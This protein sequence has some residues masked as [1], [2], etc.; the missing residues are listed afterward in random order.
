MTTMPTTTPPE[1]THRPSASGAAHGRHHLQKG[2][3][4]GPSFD[5]PARYG[6][7][8]DGGTGLVSPAFVNHDGSVTREVVQLTSGVMPT[9]GQMA[10]FERAY[11]L[12]D[13]AVSY[14][15]V[16]SNPDHTDV[17][18]DGRFPAWFFDSPGAPTERMAIVVH[19]QNGLRNDGLR[20]AD[21][22][23]QS[24]ANLPLLDITY[25]NDA[26]APA[27]PSGRLQYGATE[28]QDLDAAVTWARDRGARDIVLIGQSMGGAVVAGFLESSDQADVVSQVVLDAPMLSLSEVIDNGARSAMPVT[29][30]AVP[31]PII[32]TAKQFASLRY[33]VDWSAV[34]YLDD[35]SWVRVPTLVVHGTGDPRVPVTVSQEL[36]AA[37]PDLVTLETF[38]GALHVESWNFDRARYGDLVRS[39][40]DTTS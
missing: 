17:V 36:K 18:V 5:A 30:G 39:F 20:V 33:G 35:T 24:G 15:P 16:E 38:P 34:D 37:Q 26:G 11:W 12:G 29:G 14:D 31:A 23:A 21:V 7:A 28:W 9:A 25:R 10:A 2:P 19:G 27:D 13:P 40:L 22:L 32:W 3:D 8:W 6:L 4:A 1:A